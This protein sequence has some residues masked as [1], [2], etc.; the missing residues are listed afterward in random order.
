MCLTIL[1]SLTAVCVCAKRDLRN[2]KKPPRFNSYS[3]HIMLSITC[4]RKCITAEKQDTKQAASKALRSVYMNDTAATI[5]SAVYTSRLKS[6][7]Q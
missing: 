7:S 5:Q 6:G 1:K 2:K 3:A 4:N